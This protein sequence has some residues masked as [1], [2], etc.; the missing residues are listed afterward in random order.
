MLYKIPNNEFDCAIQTPEDNIGV[1][2]SLGSCIAPRACSYFGNLWK[3]YN[4]NITLTGNDRWIIVPLSTFASDFTNDDGS[5]YC[6][7]HV[8]YTNLYP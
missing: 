5:N 1:F 7:I 4:F 6:E 2:Q 3:T 8:E